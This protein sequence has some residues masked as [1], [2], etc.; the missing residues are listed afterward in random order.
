MKARTCRLYLVLIGAVAVAAG[1]EWADL[2]GLVSTRSV[3]HAQSLPPMSPPEPAGM[4][5]L[6]AVPG[7]SNPPRLTDEPGAPHRYGNRS[8]A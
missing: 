8:A 7:T 1:Q 3:A 6:Q 5:P 4:P 2:D